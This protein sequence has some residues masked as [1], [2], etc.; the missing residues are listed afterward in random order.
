MR[1]WDMGGGWTRVKED[2]KA[3]DWLFPQ[4]NVWMVLPRQRYRCP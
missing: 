4:V 3:T 2:S 1:R